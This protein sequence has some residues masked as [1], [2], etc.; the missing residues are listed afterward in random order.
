MKNAIWKNTL[1]PYIKTPAFISYGAFEE[2]RPVRVDC[3]LGI[4]PL[5]QLHGGALLSLDAAEYGGYPKGGAHGN[6]ALAEYLGKR[7]AKV[8]PATICFGAGSQGTISSLSRILGGANSTIL[9]IIPQFIPALLEFATAGAHLET[10]SLEGASYKIYVDNLIQALKPSTTVVYLDNPHNPTGQVV[11]LAEIAR[12]AEACLANGSLLIVDEAYGDFLDDSASALNLTHEN[13]ICMRSFSKGCG[14]AGLRVG[15]I[16]IRDEELR[17]YYKELGLHFSASAA[18]ANIAAEL[19]PKLDLKAMRS[20]VA[21]LK[22]EVL[23][24]IGKYP[25]FSVAETSEATP[26]FLVTWAQEANLYDALMEVG[27]Q[28]EPG[29]FFAMEGQRSVRLRAPMQEQ[30]VEF[31]ELWDKRFG[32]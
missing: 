2:K 5:P 20:K 6:K 26:I 32:G 30:L 18:A 25:E 9:G 8:D 28:T 13:I 17:G 24:F 7:W 16:V 11:P 3:S 29:M 14:L 31:C 23:A 15:Y 1:A 21:K 12:L 22:Q 10:I 19:L 27:I 4:N